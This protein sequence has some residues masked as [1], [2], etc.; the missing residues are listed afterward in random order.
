MKAKKTLVIVAVSAVFFACALSAQATEVTTKFLMH[1]DYYSASTSTNVPKQ[2]FLVRRARAYFGA[3]ISDLVSGQLGLEAD[4]SSTTGARTSA[5][6]DAYVDF[7]YSPL[8][9]V[10]VGMFKYDFDLS[11]RGSSAVRPFMDR[12]IVTNAVVANLTGGAPG[13]STDFRD[14]G[15][16][17]IGKADRF[18]YGV[19]VWQ[20]QGANA[21][22]NNNKN[23]YTANVWGKLAGV[24]LNLGYLSSD[25]T[26]LTPAAVTS[27]YEA[28]T[29]GVAYDTEPL[30]VQA[31]YYSA[32]RKTT[33]TQDLSGYYVSGSYTVAEN[34]DV[35]ARYQQF[36]D[37]KWGTTNNQITSTDLG[38]KYYL[39][40]KG[41]GGSNVSLNYMFRNADS[42]VT[43]KIFDERGTSVTG[44]QIDNL[45]MA[46]LQVQF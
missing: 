11:G 29:V 33:T 44:S 41:R 31:E 38:V 21:N 28:D 24:K 6:K 1:F 20:G 9:L 23:A 12:A 14:K 5:L 7:H 4:D 37:E 32:K 42:G 16:S 8:A 46:R 39:A 26:P 45:L 35:M 34:V 17:L 2:E 18:G 19:G 10:R 22:D 13:I 15:I 27:K 25:N 36:K 40:R 3:K 30:L 43:E